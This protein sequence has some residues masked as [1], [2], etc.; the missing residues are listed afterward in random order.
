MGVTTKECINKSVRILAIGIKKAT[1]YNMVKGRLSRGM[2]SD[3][4][5]QARLK[6][7]REQKEKVD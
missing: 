1:S 6:Y 4:H 5:L 3:D 7:E 2:Y